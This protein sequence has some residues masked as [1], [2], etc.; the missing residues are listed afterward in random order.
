MASV[1]PALPYCHTLFTKN[2]S[3]KVETGFPPLPHK[4]HLR[5]WMNTLMPQG[6]DEIKPQRHALYVSQK[7][8]PCLLHLTICVLH[9]HVCY[10][11]PHALTQM[12]EVLQTANSLLAVFNLKASYM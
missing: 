6:C 12:S 2:I 10:T 11:D 1:I 7:H 9:V 4:D 3:N 8:W 5:V